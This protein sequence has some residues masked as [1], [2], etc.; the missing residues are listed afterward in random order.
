MERQFVIGYGLDCREYYYNLP[1]TDE[2]AE[3]EK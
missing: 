3:G 2:Y 1:Y